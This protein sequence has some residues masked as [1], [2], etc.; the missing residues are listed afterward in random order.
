MPSHEVQVRVPSETL[1]R[2]AHERGVTSAQAGIAPE[3]AAIELLV[4][5]MYAAVDQ[6][7]IGGNDDSDEF[8]D[9]WVVWLFG[10]DIDALVG[11]ART[12]LI[13]QQMMD[14]AYAFVTDP[15]AGDFRVGR[16]ID[17]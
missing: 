4:E 13:E 11:A 5:G 6:A 9:F 8:D 3:V 1:R 10:P 15:T 16:R 14:G 12:V 7:G 17:F 2:S